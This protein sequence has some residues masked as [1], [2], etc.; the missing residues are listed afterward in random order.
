MD[1]TLAQAIKG[2]QLYNEAAG[3]ARKTCQWYDKMLNFF[4]TWLEEQLGHEPLINEVTRDFLRTYMALLRKEVEESAQQP[5][6]L[7]K[8]RIRSIRTVRGYYTTLS[9]FFN[10]AVREELIENSPMKNVAR[11]KVPRFI[12]DPYSE[13]E[14]RALLT[15]CKTMTDRSSIRMLAMILL[16]LDSGMRVGE[17]LS[18]SLDNLN[19]ELGQAKVMGKGSKERFIYFGKSSKRAL[20]RYISLARPEPYPNVSNL[21][22]TFDGRPLPHRQFAH[23]LRKLGEIAGVKKVYAHRFRRTAAV[24]FLRNGGNIFSL[25][26]LLGHES[27]DMVRWYVELAADD[28]AEAHKKASP[29]DR[30]RL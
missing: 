23:M 26:K 7:P 8:K 24:Q 12:P 14:V 30:W 2:F 19:L 27:L 5:D 9:A 13:D 18:L 22:I 4:H 20:W 6:L 28:V 29:V 11:P 1:I 10:W 17:M 3:R 25:Q 15:A 16:L 21:F